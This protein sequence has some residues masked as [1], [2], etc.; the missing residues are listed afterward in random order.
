[1]NPDFL[2]PGIILAL[3]ILLTLAVYWITSFIIF[4]HLIRFGVGTQ[5]KMIAFLFLL[6]SIALFFG[7]VMCFSAVD[8][9]AAGKSLV[10]LLGSLFQTNYLQ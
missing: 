3:L 7:S 10:T 2:T 9:E 4:Y 6:G 8:F 1:M 5:P